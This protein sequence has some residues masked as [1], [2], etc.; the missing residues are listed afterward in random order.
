L[1]G[2]TLPMDLPGRFSRL[3]VMNTTLGTG[4]VRL[5]DGFVAWR[6][7]VANNPAMDVAKL[8]GRSCPHLT[9]QECAAYAAPYPDARYMAGVRRF[10]QLVPDGMDAPG[11]EISRRARDWWQHQWQGQTFMA[12][13]MKDPV[14][15][16]P[17]MH[18]LRTTIHGC[19]PPYEHPEAG[20]FAQEWGEDIARRALTAF[21]A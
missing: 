18:S 21:A 16:P 1:L 20:H 15:G 8:L 12:I 6:A 19:P 17:V 11:A 14:L 5:S 10:P 4:D 9:P 13:G 7:W 2:L 3:L